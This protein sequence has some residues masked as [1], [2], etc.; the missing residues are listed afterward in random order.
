MCVQRDFDPEL[1]RKEHE[2]NALPFSLSPF[3]VPGEGEEPMQELKEGELRVVAP[4]EVPWIDLLLDIAMTTAFASLT[5]GTPIL[6]WDSALSYVCYFA[7]VWWIWVSQVAYNMRFRQADWLHRI[8]VFAQLAIF[9]ALAAF[10]R[11]FDITVGLITNHDEALT[12]QLLAQLKN[13]NQIA[14]FDLRGERLPR[15]NAK[16]LSMVMAVSRLVLLL[17]YVIVF[18]HARK[19]KRTSLVAHMASL[20][21]SS[22]C[23]FTAFAILGSTNHP[24][25]VPSHN[26]EVIKLVLWYLPILVEIASHFVAL[27]LPGFVGYSTKL[28]DNDQV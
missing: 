14:A 26:A 19:L 20:L 11:D 21:F 4:A 23:Y 24:N 10:T 8:W 28:I 18:Y 27:N 17:Q 15:L 2:A 12:D 7:F 13:R 3:P 5:E 9:S 16:G 6:T 1:L 25:F 22:L